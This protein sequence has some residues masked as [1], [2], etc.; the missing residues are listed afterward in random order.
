MGKFRDWGWLHKGIRLG[1]AVGALHVP[2]YA[3][4][5]SFFI[6]LAVFPGL[7][8]VAGAMQLTPL[9][10]YDLSSM[11]RGFLPSVLMDDAE[12]LI[13][14]AYQNMSGATLGLSA[15]TMLWSAGRGVYGILKGLNA[16]YG[17]HEDRGYLRT[18]LISMVYTF[19][20][21]LVLVLTLALHVFGSHLLSLIRRMESPVV[22]FLLKYVNLR[23]FLLLILQ[24]GLFTALFMALPNRR[25][26]FWDSLPGALLASMG[27]LV[28]SDLFSMYVEHFAGLSNMFGSVYAV[29]L[30]MLWLY[31]CMSIVFY[32]GALN[33][34]LTDW[35]RKNIADL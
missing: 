17:V 31:F 10:A 6:I 4:N 33:A 15:V 25:N 26:R 22:Q 5:A 19:A 24:T 7:I 21:L 28:F 9:D 12:A 8:L 32:G 3:A 1:R 20:L 11:L 14:L 13:A 16:I 18:R 30:S 34:C 29:S 27:W 23:F 35:G 2:L